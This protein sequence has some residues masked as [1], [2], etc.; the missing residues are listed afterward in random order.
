MKAYASS[1]KPRKTPS[2]THSENVESKTTD[3]PEEDSYR[4]FAE[5]AIDLTFL[6]GLRALLLFL[7][8]PL[9]LRCF[10]QHFRDCH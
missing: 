3:L 10:R 9:C 1:I 6:R 5:E 4:L 8:V 2:R 7:L